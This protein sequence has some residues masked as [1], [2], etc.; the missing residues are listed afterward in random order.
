[1]MTLYLA[2]FSQGNGQKAKQWTTP[3]HLSLSQ[4]Q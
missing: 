4:A 3:K 1:M 2:P